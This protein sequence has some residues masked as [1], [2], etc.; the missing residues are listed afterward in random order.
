MHT[1]PQGGNRGRNKQLHENG[2]LGVIDR[3]IY[4]VS[5]NTLYR[6]SKNIKNIKPTVILMVPAIHV[7]STYPVNIIEMS[8]FVLVYHDITENQ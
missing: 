2:Q 8:C 7:S 5:Q 3:I 4:R 1:K 6:L